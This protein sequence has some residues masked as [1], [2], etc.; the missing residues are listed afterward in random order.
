MTNQERTGEMRS[1]YQ[2]DSRKGRQWWASKP[3]FLLG[4]DIF[5][6]KQV[7]PKQG[8]RIIRKFICKTQPGGCFTSPKFL[9]VGY[10]AL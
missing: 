3:T 5:Q 1:A 9:K 4:F 2:T 7:V 8:Q 10:I 6:G